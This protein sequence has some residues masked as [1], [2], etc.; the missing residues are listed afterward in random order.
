MSRSSP[1]ASSAAGPPSEPHASEANSPPP[2]A[3]EPS[4]TP[5]LDEELPYISRQY[6]QSSQVLIQELRSYPTLLARLQA[7]YEVAWR[8]TR[9][10]LKLFLAFSVFT[11]EEQR[12]RRAQELH[13]IRMSIRQAK[14]GQHHVDGQQL[15]DLEEREHSLIAQDGLLAMSQEVSLLR[16]QKL[17]A[18]EE[19]DEL[20]DA[21]PLATLEDHRAKAEHR[22]PLDA[23][24][25]VNIE[26][27]D[28]RLD[29]LELEL[30]NGY[31]YFR[32][33]HKFN[34]MQLVDALAQRMTRETQLMKRVQRE[35]ES[36]RLSLLEHEESDL[37]RLEELVNAL[38]SSAG[39]HSG[40]LKSEKRS[41]TQLNRRQLETARDRQVRTECTECR[42]GNVQATGSVGPADYR[43]TCEL[44]RCFVCREVH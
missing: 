38:Q 13:H 29:Q 23:A 44:A 42:H 26:S 4:A 17:C 9:Q 7:A 36:R 20:L 21:M 3:L 5:L 40:G 8:V 16:A 19:L 25:F 6:F 28:M 12:Q 18:Q 10:A 2:A 41:L 35:R 37:A 43:E 33:P 14:H 31:A 34:N 22:R 39:Q 30:S 11:D 1:C 15:A 32:D 24:A 27:L